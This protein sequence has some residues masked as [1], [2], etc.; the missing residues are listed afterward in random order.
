MTR[1]EAASK[2]ACPGRGDVESG[3]ASLP[4]VMGTEHAAEGDRSRGVGGALEKA[5]LHP[6]VGP[7]I[8]S[9]L[10]NINFIKSKIYK[11]KEIG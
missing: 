8:L 9:L 11:M 5:A 7:H 4:R 10:D 1:E 6:L 3:R 2:Q